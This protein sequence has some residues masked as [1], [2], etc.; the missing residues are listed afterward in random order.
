MGFL[1]GYVMGMNPFTTVLVVLLVIFIPSLW[2]FFKVGGFLWNI[3]A[4]FLEP[5]WE[6][7]CSL[8]GKAAD[9]FMDAEP[10]GKVIWIFILLGAIG[11]IAHLLR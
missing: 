8:F 2:L 9:S 1:W 3:F 11:A 4:F 5:L 7:I 10:A 6:G